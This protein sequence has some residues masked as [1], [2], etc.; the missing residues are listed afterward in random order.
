MYSIKDITFP[1]TTGGGPSWGCTTI[2]VFSNRG[3]WTAHLWE[4][5]NIFKDFQGSLDFLRNGNPDTDYPSLAQARAEFFGPDPEN[6]EA[7]YFVN[8]FIFTPNAV[9]ERHYLDR[10]DR[11]IGPVEGPLRNG[12]PP[13]DPWWYPQV[14]RLIEEITEIVPEVRLGSILTYPVVR[15]MQQVVGTREGLE[16]GLV[17]W[18]YVPRHVHQTQDGRCALTRAI[19]IT[20]PVG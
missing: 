11:I 15:K 13:T 1:F 10:L 7:A 19:R 20:S 9:E 14:N 6:N 4:A 5:A 2:I 16:N 18:E 17:V 3:V 12:R 8:A